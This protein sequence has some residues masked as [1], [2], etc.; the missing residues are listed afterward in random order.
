MA[1]AQAKH[2]DPQSATT[3]IVSAFTDLQKAGP[4]DVMAFYTALME[5]VGDISA[6]V[7]QFVSERMAEDI[8]TQQEVLSC[9]NPTDLMQVQ[10]RFLQKAF[11]Q[12]AAETGKL[13]SI[14]NAALTG[15]LTR[16]LHKRAKD[17]TP[18]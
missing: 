12:Y 16:H 18:L 2:T 3:D 15:A 7:A 1:R 8:R 11:D 14:G 5:G 6:E 10:M 17:N 13:V 9:S 4:A